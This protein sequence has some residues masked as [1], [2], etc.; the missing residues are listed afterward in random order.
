MIYQSENLS[1]V[2]DQVR[3]EFDFEIV[4]RPLVGSLNAG[5]TVPTDWFACF[6]DDTFEPVGP[7]SVKDGYVP[8]TTEDVVTLVEAAIDGFNKGVTEV[9]T[10]F[11]K[12]GHFVLVSPSSE[13]QRTVSGKDI[14]FP[15]LLI[16]AGL[17]GSSS[18]RCT[19]GLFRSLCSNLELFQTFKSFSVSIRHTRH[20]PGRIDDLRANFAGLQEGWVNLE[21]VI[22]RASKRE[23]EIAEILDRIYPQPA[24]NASQRSA[25]IHRDRTRAIVIRLTRERTSG[26][27]GLTEAGK[28][29]AWE[30]F[31]AVQGYQLHDATRHGKR[32]DLQRA[33]LANNTPPVRK[34]EELLLA[35]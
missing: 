11:T 18:F 31:N 23:V 15:R 2:L 10:E 29:T 8:H 28:A 3:N 1:D 20:L 25:T 9:K 16:Q 14:V 33:I 24:D 26:G 5:R 35:V 17:G 6:R 21:G 32:S 22:D 13:Y 4:K 19:L 27:Y 30:L 12:N 34:A 7:G